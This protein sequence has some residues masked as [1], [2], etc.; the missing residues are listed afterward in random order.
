MFYKSEEDLK[1]DVVDNLES[2]VLPL[3]EI[4]INNF[5]CF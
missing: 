1:G 5:C 3:F 4:H 2:L